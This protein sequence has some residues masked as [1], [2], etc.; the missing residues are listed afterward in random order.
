VDESQ[1]TIRITLWGSQAEQFD[2]TDSPVIA[3]KGARINDFNGRSLSLGVASTYKLN[4]N[5]PESNH[6]KQWYTEKGINTQ[7][8]S[9]SGM[10]SSSGEGVTKRNKITLQEAK[11]ENLGMGDKPDYFEFRGTVVFLKSENCA[12]PGCPECKKKMTMEANGWR[13]EKCQKTFG[14]PE[15]RYILT[16]SVE[17]ATSQIYLNAFDD[18][19]NTLLKMS[20]NEIMAL[21]ENDATASQVI[22]NKALFQSFNFKV[23]AK[24]ETYNV[25]F[26]LEFM[27][28]LYTKISLFYRKLLVLNTLVWSLVLLT[29]LKK[30]MRLLPI[31]KSS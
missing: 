30:L 24:Q 6:L 25:S 31:L 19:G 1:K 18:Q 11:S 17:D 13:C 9:Y 26:C 22:F 15:Y 5:T 8:D 2:A 28:A 3:C 21:K 10:V 29:M 7:F 16:M 14:S 4:P 27:H 23:R 20:A 12:Y